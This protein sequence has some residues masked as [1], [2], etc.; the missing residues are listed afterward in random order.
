M[1][2]L[3]IAQQIL[4]KEIKPK[5]SNTIW[6]HKVRHELRKEFNF[7]CKLCGKKDRLCFHHI[8]PIDDDY[9]RGSHK[10]Y[11]DYKEH[12]N[13]IILLCK[14]CHRIVHKVMII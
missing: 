2:S 12:N 13:V 11:K 7:Q 8:I 5:S 3:Q 1:N 9:A 6:C 4:K 14:S 10:R